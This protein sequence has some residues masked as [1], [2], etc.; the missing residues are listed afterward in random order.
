MGSRTAVLLFVAVLGA[1]AASSALAA[2]RTVTLR[3][4]EVAATPTVGT[5]AGTGSSGSAWSAVVRHTRISHGRATIR[6]GSFRLASIPVSGAKVVARGR[7]TAG[8]VRLMSQA[9]GCGKQVYVVRG[10]LAFHSGAGSMT[11]HLTHHRKRV[12]GRCL[13][14]AATVTGTARL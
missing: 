12:L 11:V 6:G 3:G 9:P 13:A 7:F 1:L 5:F 10:R 4:V 14:Y 8:T 2:S